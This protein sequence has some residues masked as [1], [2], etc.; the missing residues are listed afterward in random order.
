MVVA[1]LGVARAGVS[2]L[3]L[4]SSTVVQRLRK[5]HS[6]PTF[7]DTPRQLTTQQSKCVC[8]IETLLLLY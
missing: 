8:L 2:E 4:A 3:P 6:T 1:P 7:D 5:I